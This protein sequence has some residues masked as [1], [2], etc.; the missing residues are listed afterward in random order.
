MSYKPEKICPEVNKP[1]GVFQFE[2]KVGWA[3]VIALLALL[4]AI[5]APLYSY[6][7]LQDAFREQST[8]ANGFK[9]WGIYTS[10]TNLD[11]S[12]NYTTYHVRLRN[13]SELSISEVQLSYSFLNQTILKDDDHV[14]EIEPPLSHKVEHSENRLLVTL[15]KS[16]SPGLE[17][18]VSLKI[19]LPLSSDGETEHVHPIS[20]ALTEAS[21]KQLIWQLGG[22]G[23]T[24]SF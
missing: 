23:G 8:K 22:F 5:S 4:I 17:G 11:E 12:I 1:A 20:W 21:S 10:Y 24:S 2:P 6:Y 3:E 13:D 7:W 15:D 19:P 16:F 14:L 18:L 9:A